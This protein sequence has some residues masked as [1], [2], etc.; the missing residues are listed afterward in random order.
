MGLFIIK[1]FL[2]FY[3]CDFAATILYYFYVNEKIALLYFV[4]FGKIITK[5]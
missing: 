2:S 3:N 5:F 4:F 1:N